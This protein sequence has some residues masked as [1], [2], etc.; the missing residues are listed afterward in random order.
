LVAIQVSISVRHI[1]VLVVRLKF[2][3]TVPR[4]RADS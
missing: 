2:H 4:G 3:I 1:S